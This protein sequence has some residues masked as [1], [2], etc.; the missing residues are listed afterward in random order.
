[1][2]KLEE[3]NSMIDYITKLKEA[4][5]NVDNTVMLADIAKSLA[6]IADTFYKAESE[7]LRKIKEKIVE[8]RDNNKYEN[9]DVTFVCRFLANYMDVLEKQMSGSENMNGWIPI[10]ERLPEKNMECL[11][12][13]GKFNITEI[14]TYSDLMGIID[15]RIFY[16]GEVGYHNFKDIT[17]Y[18]KAWMPLPKPYETQESEDKYE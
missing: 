9:K 7:V 8:I 12:T 6:M 14:A 13:V 17:K 2:S 1:M 3:T 11:V 5:L 16:K 15:H 18:V 10:S 4:G